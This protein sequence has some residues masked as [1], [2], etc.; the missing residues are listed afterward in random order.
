[1]AG[2]RFELDTR[3]IRALLSSPEMGAAME[4]VAHVA[5]AFAV[6]ISP[7]RTGA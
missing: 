2:V 3:G 5:V 6:E 4:Q 1:M 7:R